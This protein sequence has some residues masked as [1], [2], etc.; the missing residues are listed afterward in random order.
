MYKFNINQRIEVRLRPNQYKLV[1]VWPAVAVAFGICRPVS[2]VSFL[3]VYPWSRCKKC[4]CVVV[5]PRRSRSC[6]HHFR[7]LITCDTRTL[8]WIFLALSH[9]FR[10]LPRLTSRSWTPFHLADTS[11]THFWHIFSISF[12]LFRFDCRRRNDLLTI[13]NS[14]VCFDGEKKIHLANRNRFVA[15]LRRQMKSHTEHFDSS[16]TFEAQI[17]SIHFKTITTANN[18]AGFH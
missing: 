15:R 8:S 12:Q 4:S 10:S 2:F 16:S 17:R 14:F 9:H 1:L 3:C 13:S 11:Y 5:R 6:G 7:L 18:L